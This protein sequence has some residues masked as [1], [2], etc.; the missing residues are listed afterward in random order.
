MLLDCTLRDGAHVNGGNFGLDNIERIINSLMLSKVDFIEL[1]FL[2]DKELNQDSTFFPS[3]SDA[4]QILKNIDIENFNGSFCLM[5]RTDRFSLD[6]LQMQKGGIDTIRYAFYP[7][8]IA[9]LKQ[10]VIK[11]RELGY[12]I[13]LNPINVTMYSE[14]ELINII[15]Q[16]NDLDIEGVAIVDTFG[17]LELNAFEQCVKLF[18]DNLNK[19]F[20]LGLH[21]HENLSLSFG[22]IQFFEKM[23]INRTFIYDGSLLGMGR[24]PGNL[25]LELVMSYLNQSNKDRY[26]PHAVMD[27]IESVIKPIKLQRD[28]GYSPIYMYSAIL[29]IHRTYPEY[30]YE[31]KKFSFKD[32]FKIMD[33]VKEEKLGNEFDQ[34]SLERLI[35]NYAG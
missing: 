3:V 14:I 9:D 33:I 23:S 29:G 10:Y 6:N 8:H 12:K 4:E 5:A 18:D 19:N 22:M 24:I 27:V 16:L 17:S 25:P 26:N 32:I 11:T 28:W 2:E 7:E 30:L 31:I 21:L 15:N 35:E 1:G 20:T 34:K 13:Y